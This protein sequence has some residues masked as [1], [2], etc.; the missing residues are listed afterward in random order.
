MAGRE[1]FGIL[2]SGFLTDDRAG[3]AADLYTAKGLARE[4]MALATVCGHIVQLGLWA[5][6]ETDDGVIPGDGVAAIHQATMMPRS[7][8]RTVIELLLEAK[9]LRTEKGGLYLVGFVDCYASIL[10]QRAANRE[11]ARN[12]RKTAPPKVETE[13]KNSTSAPRRTDVGSPSDTTVR[14]VPAVPSASERNGTA[15]S[16]DFENSHPAVS[17]GAALASEAAAAPPSAGAVERTEVTQPPAPRPKTLA[18][19]RALGL[20]QETA[21]RE[22]KAAAAALAKPKREPLPAPPPDDAEFRARIRA[23]I[24]A[25]KAPLP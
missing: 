10:N 3:L 21:K 7:A 13:P 12:N 22:S 5:M 18:E 20:A 6:R 9:L 14:A 4:D 23:G 25:A 1:D 17:V 8:C 24:E 16:N 15:G 2:R 19:A 11:Y